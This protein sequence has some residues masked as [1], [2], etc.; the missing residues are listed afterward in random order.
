[1]S[2]LLCKNFPFFWVLFFV[3]VST[4]AWTSHS[5]AKTDT[6]IRVGTYKNAP[7]VFQSPDGEIKGFFVDILN[8][9]AKKE[10]WKIVYQHASWA[11]QLDNLKNGKIDLL[12]DIAYASAREKIFDFNK[13]SV[14]INWGEVFVQPNSRIHS[15]IDLSGKMVAVVKGD[16]HSDNFKIMLQGFAVRCTFVEVGSYADV[17]AMI[18]DGR[19]DAGVV[20]QIFGLLNEV[21][22]TVKKSSIIFHPT[23]LLF[24]APKGKNQTL[25]EAIDRRIVQLKADEQS[26]YHQAMEQWLGSSSKSK[27]KFPKWAPWLLAAVAFLLLLAIGIN[28]LLRK[29]VA[30]R[31]V[32]LQKEIQERRHFEKA[33]KEANEDLERIV[34]E[35][36]QALTCANEHL[37]QAKEEADHASVAKSEFLANMSHEIRTP[38][39]AIMGLTDLALKGELHPKTRDHLRK[40]RTSSRSLLRIINEILDFSKIEAGK[41]EIEDTCFHLAELFENLGNLFRHK[42]MENNIEF[43][44]SLPPNLFVEV[45][46]DPLRLEQILVNLLSNA[47]KFTQQGEIVVQASL[48]EES[49]QNLMVQFSVRDTGIGVSEENLPKLFD[50]FTQADTS[51]SRKYGGTGLGLAI[52]KRLIEMMGGTFWAESQL[53]QGS[54]FFFTTSFQRVQQTTENNLNLP[55]SLRGLN[56]L[57]VD[58]NDTAREIIEE[59]IKEFPLNPVGVD[60]GEKAMQLLQESA[61]NGHYFDL[62]L[63]DWR[64][65]G[66]DGLETSSLIREDITLSH[67]LNLIPP[68]IGPKI[69]LLSAFGQEEMRER[70]E[71]IGL[72]GFLEKPVSRFLLFDTILE[73]FGH[74]VTK[75]FRRDENAIPE[76]RVRG[77]LGGNQLLLV[78]DHPINQEVAQEILSG[79]NISIKI[80]NNGVEALEWLEKQ[81]FDGVLMDL[82]MPIMD[83]YEATKHIRSNPNYA[84]L[85]IIAMTAH[86]L[87]GELKKC[88]AAG[89]N[90]HVS[91]PIDT[92]ILFT[93]LLKWLP[94]KNQPIDEPQE[95]PQE[96]TA[97]STSHSDSVSKDLWLPG[98]LEGIDVVSGLKRLRNNK[99]L[100]HRLLLDFGREYANV[101]QDIQ[102]SL[103]TSTDSEHGL[104]LIHTV[105]GLAGNIAATQLH[106]SARD[107]ERAIKENRPE[108]IKTQFF[109]FQSFLTQVLTSIQ[110]LENTPI[111]DT[112]SNVGEKST[113]T[114]DLVKVKKCLLELKGY[115][116]NFDSKAEQSL[117][118]LQS[119]LSGTETE[120]VLEELTLCLDRFDFPAAEKPLQALGEKVGIDSL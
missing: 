12:V 10:G 81:T 56:V 68:Q 37:Q 91:K 120:K 21:D 19:V 107:L 92:D 14:L 51:I 28:L 113:E 1:M 117:E 104:R 118:V 11:K 48:V 29:K 57:I 63:M 22:F 5:M 62:I 59:T 58:D 33:L 24:A 52:C 111:K 27:G 99:K 43:V 55:E 80:A 69:L 41:M 25:L 85:P 109:Q 23:N 15:V 105:K 30:S 18:S 60:S 36:T 90:D 53:D 76:S 106:E 44:L 2:R 9:V 38:M 88:L 64:L 49:K 103:D 112:Q 83:G 96:Q 46:G 119:L 82:Q 101:I 32:A 70:T 34:T 116:S 72:D 94:P 42:V 89:M 84:Q 115:I 40:V 71:A 114:V 95:Q 65:P 35:R 97:H 61:K 87:E 93:S 39:N 3:F 86:A 31:T 6:T 66:M 75:R 17:F 102:T 77:I 73:V 26:V 110:T 8:Y 45:V 98:E 16:I 79:I 100:Y 67:T 47:L 74:K 20:N 78:E 7:L 4:M 54:T 13:E 50:A 108:I